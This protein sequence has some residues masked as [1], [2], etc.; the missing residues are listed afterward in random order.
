MSG[1]LL[2]QAGRVHEG[3]G[4]RGARDAHALAPRQGQAVGF[5]LSVTN[6]VLKFRV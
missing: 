6:V 4:A 3:E 5:G 1:S 2:P